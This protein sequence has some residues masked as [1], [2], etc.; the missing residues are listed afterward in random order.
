LAIESLNQRTGKPTK[1][2]GG[3]SRQGARRSRLCRVPAA[4]DVAGRR[5]PPRRSARTPPAVAGLA[6]EAAADGGSAIVTV[7]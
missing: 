1:A 6:F 4:L 7:S 3:V 2:G 5:R